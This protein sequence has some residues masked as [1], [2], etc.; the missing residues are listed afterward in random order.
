MK[1]EQWALLIMGIAAAIA[2]AVL[3]RVGAHNGR[4]KRVGARAVDNGKMV[5]HSGKHRAIVGG[6]ITLQQ[7]NGLLVFPTPT[8]TPKGFQ[9]IPGPKVMAGSTSSL[10]S[11]CG[12][13]LLR[14]RRE[15]GELWFQ[16][17]ASP[18]NVLSCWHLVGA[19]IKRWQPTG[20]HISITNKVPVL[21]MYTGKKVWAGDLGDGSVVAIYG[22][23][24]RKGFA[25][26]GIV[27]RLWLTKAGVLV[28]TNSPSQ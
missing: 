6:S 17:P 22:K 15:Q 9:G 23:M 16:E 21:M 1:I 11:A 4:A 13:K 28:K 5:A 26:S 18:E 20:W 24:T 7:L 12:L 25:L 14:V 8:A 10:H 27:V 2:V 3:L 19:A